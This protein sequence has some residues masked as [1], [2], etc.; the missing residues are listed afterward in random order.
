V[1]AALLFGPPFLVGFGLAFATRK[2]RVVV[3]IGV[4]LAVAFVLWVYLSAP[5]DFAH[6]EG[7]SDGEMF[8][9]RFWEPGFT[10]FLTAGGLIGWLAGVG[11]GIL[12]RLWL[13]LRR[14]DASD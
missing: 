14:I 5:H 11:C 2:W 10:V 7:D 9:G 3:L 12:I 4:A 6:S 1:F 13:D 8:L